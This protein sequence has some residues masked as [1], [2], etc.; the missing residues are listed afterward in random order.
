VLAATAR[1]DPRAWVLGAALL[2][3]SNHNVGF[4]FVEARPDMVA[5]LLALLALFL[6]SEWERLQRPSGPAAFPRM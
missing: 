5:A 2:F 6:F 3:A 4:Y 1:R